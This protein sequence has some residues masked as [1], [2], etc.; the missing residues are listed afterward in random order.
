MTPLHRLP[1]G[2]WVDLAKIEPIGV[3]V[4]SADDG[5]SSFVT[6]H[7]EGGRAFISNFPTP[8]AA[9]AYA[10]ELA[11]LVNDARLAERFRASM[12]GFQPQ[13]YGI[14]NFAIDE[15]HQWGVTDW[16]KPT[17]ARIRTFGS[18]W[19]F[20]KPHTDAQPTPA[21]LHKTANTPGDT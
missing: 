3:G 14:D 19:D 9:Q 4:N 18:E 6:A 8:E 2:S 10:D 12:S 11:G 5:A 1:N 17:Y 20:G 15:R 21:D 13:G 16:R 7:Y